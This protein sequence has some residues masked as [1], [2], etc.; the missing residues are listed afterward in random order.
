L[1]FFFSLRG[2]LDGLFGGFFLPFFFVFLGKLDG[3]GGIQEG[4]QI[5]CITMDG[6]MELLHWE[7]RGNLKIADTERVL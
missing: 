3:E 1:C 6:W 4:S 5:F 2:L 7:K